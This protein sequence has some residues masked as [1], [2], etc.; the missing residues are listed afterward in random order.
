MNVLYKF[1][2]RLCLTIALLISTLPLQAKH[3]KTPKNKSKRIALELDLP[4]NF[5]KTHFIVGHSAEKII[6]QAQKKTPEVDIQNIPFDLLRDG[7]IK[8]AFFSPDDGVLK[9]LLYFIAHEKESIKMAAYALTDQAIADAL[10]QAHK[11]GINIEIVADRGCLHERNG[12]IPFLIKQGIPV[13]VLDDIRKKTKT[14]LVIRGIMHH[15]Y[16]VFTKNMLD[17]KILWTGSFNFTKNAHWNNQENVLVLDDAPVVKKYS[18][19][20]DLL[21]QR[22]KK[23]T[24][25]DL[26]NK[27]ISISQRKKR[28]N[29][30]EK[31]IVV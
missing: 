26:H 3:H 23:R 21:K 4:A 17:K 1:F 28:R 13:F 2:M 25:Q 16:I 6:S 5:G 15:K 11:R 31:N 19:Q 29:T 24:I 8:Q 14:G 30:L 20:F 27:N 9:V 18:Q 10:I 7:D 12:K 22:S